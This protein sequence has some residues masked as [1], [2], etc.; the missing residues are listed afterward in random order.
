MIQCFIDDGSHPVVTSWDL[1]L[2]LLG[3]DG[4]FTNEFVVLCTVGY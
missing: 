2:G 4:G 1:V 3:T